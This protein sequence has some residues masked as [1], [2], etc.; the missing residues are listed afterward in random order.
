MKIKTTITG[1]THEDLVD[2]LSTATYGSN[3]FAVKRPK[4]SYKGTALEEEGLCLEDTWAKILLNGGKLFFCDYYA[5]DEED[6]YGNLPHIWKG[7]YMRY[8]VTLEDVKKGLEK[9]INNG[10]WHAKY[11]MNL[12]NNDGELDITQAEALVQIIVFGE[13]V[14]G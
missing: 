8:E 13:E 6:F 1:I 3:W 9:A 10:G 7:D 5:E 4:G 11:V 12:M 14:Y 2:F